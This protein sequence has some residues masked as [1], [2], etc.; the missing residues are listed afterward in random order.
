MLHPKYLKSDFWGHLFEELLTY[1]IV[2]KH[3][4]AP[5]YHSLVS[6]Q[7]WFHGSD[8]GLSSLKLL[9]CEKHY[10][11]EG[12]RENIFK[13]NIFSDTPLLYKMSAGM[14]ISVSEHETGLHHVH[15][16]LTIGE[17]D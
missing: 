11:L 16:C 10:L 13:L 15:T 7:N 14:N 12:K 9:G 17:R 3:T 2:H 5:V 1:F 6:A 4:A 8:L